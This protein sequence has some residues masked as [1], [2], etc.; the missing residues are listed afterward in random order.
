M[1]P[2]KVIVL[3]TKKKEEEENFSDYI[4]VITIPLTT[5]DTGAEVVSTPAAESEGV[6]GGLG[7]I[8]QKLYNRL[9]VS[10]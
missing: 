5:G 6:G 3:V 4:T 8:V 10:C 1:Q 9:I 2:P 7:G